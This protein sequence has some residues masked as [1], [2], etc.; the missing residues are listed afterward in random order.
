MKAGLIGTLLALLFGTIFTIAGYIAGFVYGKPL[1]DQAKASESWPT[2]AGQ[3]LTSEL[4]SHRSDGKTM[5]KPLVVYR[6]DVDDEEFESDRIWFGGGYSTNDRAAMQKIVKD[7]PVD[8]EVKVHY[9]PASPDVSVL[10]PGAFTSSYALFGGGMVALVLGGIA[11]AVVAVKFII[12]IVALVTAG[13][14]EQNSQFGDNVYAED[15]HRQGFDR[16]DPFDFDDDDDA[17]PGIPGS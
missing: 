3:V 14:P 6:Y 1:L 4:D 12:V 10:L 15:L 16:P 8:S 13:G 5:Y 17:F 7:Y 9:D 11:L 2:V